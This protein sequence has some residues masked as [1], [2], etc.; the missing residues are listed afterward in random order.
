ML[1]SYAF[2][3]AALLLQTAPVQERFALQAIPRTAADLS[4][5]FTPAQVDILEKL[6]RRDREHLVRID[7][8]VPGI[9]VPTTWEEDERVYSP[10]PREWAAAASHPKFIVVHQPSQAFA[11]YEAGTLVDGDRPALGARRHRPPRAASI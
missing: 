8:P 7:P 3:V 4:K 6:N 2:G 9:V 5:R 10:F 11:A 1:R